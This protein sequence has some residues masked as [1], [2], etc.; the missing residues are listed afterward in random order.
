[1]KRKKYAA[2]LFCIVLTLAGSGL[3]ALAVARGMPAYAQLSKPPLTPPSWLFPVAWSLLYIL[4]GSS[5][6]RI[7]LTERP[8]RSW[9]LSLYALQLILNWGWSLWFFALQFR[10]FALFWLGLMILSLT[11]MIKAFSVLDKTAGRLQLPYL[12]WSVFA[13]YLNLGVWFLNRASGAAK[14]SGVFKHRSFL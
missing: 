8:A 3:S 9:A 1:M 11:R 7:W 13:A 10:L 6:A 2:Y 4:L 5:A 12:L 14:K